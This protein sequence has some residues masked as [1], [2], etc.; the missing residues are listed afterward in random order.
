[1]SKYD[2][3]DITS[4]DLL[5]YNATCPEKI[6]MYRDHSTAPPNY[7]IT[8]DDI[9]W[10]AG[11]GGIH[12]REH[13]MFYGYGHD[14]YHETEVDLHNAAA[15]FL[16]LEGVTYS[17]IKT[18]R[19]LNGISHLY[20]DASGVC[21]FGKRYDHHGKFIP[22]EDGLDIRVYTTQSTGYHAN[23]ADYN[24]TWRDGKMHIKLIEL[25]D[26]G[27][28]DIRKKLKGM[29]EAD[30]YDVFLGSIPN[31]LRDVYERTG[32]NHVEALTEVNNAIDALKVY[33][34]TYAEW[35]VKQ[36]GRAADIG[37]KYLRWLDK[38]K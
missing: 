27:T 20:I 36:G 31:I 28:D 19:P 23:H 4:D 11:S 3:Y 35:L 37:T 38:Q 2:D 24:I 7:D 29:L 9:D 13:K 34:R 25:K 14:Y 21:Y 10:T 8:P 18:L 15:A 12:R 6:V 5:R 26:D 17:K 32:Y 22:G 16:G 1:M 30:E 33:G